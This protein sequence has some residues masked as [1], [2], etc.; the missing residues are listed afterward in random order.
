MRNIIKN[1]KGV[2]LIELLV[3]AVLLTIAAVSS[4]AV[5]LSISSLSS[6]SRDELEANTEIG[7]WI[8]RVRTGAT[9]N[10]TWQNLASTTWRDLNAATSMLQTNYLTQWPL[11]TQRTSTLN[12]NADY[13]INDA[14]F[15]SNTNYRFRRVDLRVRWDE[16]R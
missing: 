7:G 5:F 13:Q 6:L 3:S 9:V 15:N 16:K 12:L 10:T 4:Y 2:T 11:S 1:N 14:N 8:E